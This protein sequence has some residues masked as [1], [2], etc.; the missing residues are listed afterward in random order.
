VSTGQVNNT[1]AAHPKD[2]GRRNEEAVFVRAAMP[3]RL[4]HPARYVFAQF[5]LLNPDNTTDSTH[6]ALLY[7]EPGCSSTHTV[8]RCAHY[9]RVCAAPR[10]QNCGN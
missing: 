9:A 1:K 5:G 4:H 3:N 6:S 10:F 2:C 7:R 8:A